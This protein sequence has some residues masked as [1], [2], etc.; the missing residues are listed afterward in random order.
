MFL[1]CNLWHLWFDVRDDGGGVL[2]GG[3]YVGGL[4]PLSSKYRAAHSGLHGGDRLGVRDAATGAATT[5][6]HINRQHK[7]F[8]YVYMQ[9]TVFILSTIYLV[10]LSNFFHFI[11]SVVLFF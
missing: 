9:I 8:M 7:A 1:S 11:F 4:L 2:L 5:K 3:G 10:N 6:F